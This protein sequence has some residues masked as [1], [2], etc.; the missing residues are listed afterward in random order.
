M[1]Q[2]RKILIVEDEMIVQLHLRRIVEQIGHEVV[3][4]AT[5]M[6]EAFE[7]AER[8]PPDLVLMDIQLA[9]GSD[10]VETA[11]V[12][13]ERFECGVIFATAYADDATI[14][15]T[16]AVAS[17]GYIVKP[18]SAPEVR[19]AISS[20]VGTQARLKS[21]RAR[22]RS[23]TSVLVSMGDAVLVTN[24][25]G[26]VT[27]AN[28]KAAALTGTAAEQLC[29]R[30]LLDVL[31]F[32]S[33][34]DT[35][36]VG[37]AMRRC[38]D[39]GERDVFPHVGIATGDGRNLQMCL[40]IE[41]LRES[42]SASAGLVVTVRH[43]GAVEVADVSRVSGRKEPFGASTRMIM[44]SHDTFGLGHLRR[45][46][47][48]AHALV[49][50]YPGIS[51]LLITGSPM[52]HRHR[53][54]QGMDYVKLPAIRKVG[55]ESYE[56]RSLAMSNEGI[57]A[58]RSSLLLGTIRDYDPNVLLV[59]HAPAGSKGELRDSLAWLQRR[60]GC[61]RI[62]GL[63]DIID[64]PTEVVPMWRE[65]GIF[66]LLRES[67]D[68]VVVYG[69]REVY[70]PVAMYEFPD[71]IA[72]KT[73]FVGYVC[74]GPEVDDAGAA[75]ALDGE[76]G[77]PLVTVTIG[78]G[79]GG[80]PE[81]IGNFL[82]MMTRF[83]DRIDFHAKILTGPFMDAD[84]AEHFRAIARDLPGEIETFVP[85]T[86][87][88]YAASDVVISTAGYNTTTDVLAYARRSIIIPRI[89]HRQEQ[90]LRAHCLRKLGLTACIHPDDVTPEILF[91][92]IT[93]VRAE[94][95][96]PLARCRAERRVP[97][98]GAQKFAEFC[99]ALLVRTRTEASVEMVATGQA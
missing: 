31:R 91:N 27:F 71:E 30:D 82:A 44:Y 57:Q 62:L 40:D 22:E 10:G 39:S 12:L 23:L 79:D 55:K 59:D 3:G 81:V 99:G 50:K 73:R 16:A 66:D 85:S 46:L 64:D 32:S 21:T 7:A 92:T 20:A 63:R 5:T 77:P 37:D 36:A 51:I 29:D 42:D 48:L 84:L 14:D 6:L 34:A 78:G 72:A 28:P 38:M 74:D 54:P 83:K 18:Y 8:T 89:L 86:A 25:R 68:H 35:R 17:A 60:G 2:P 24:E 56:A 76:A 4:T 97:L 65:R 69:A 33:E 19:A 26:A 43:P 94:E 58:L 75:S 1:M 93:R 47:K 87:A 96:A 80:G 67:Y 9:D 49:E 98:D 95:D 11:R 52:V 90:L 88:L 61:T 45:C 70:D 53:L 13:S 15:R 41:P